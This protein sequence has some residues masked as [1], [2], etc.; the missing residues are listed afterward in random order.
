MEEEVLFKPVL[1]P[2]ENVIFCDTIDHNAL[3][4]ENNQAL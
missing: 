2:K 4:V 1:G 3:G